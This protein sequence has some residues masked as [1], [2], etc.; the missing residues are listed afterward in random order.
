[1][2]ESLTK[3]SNRATIVEFYNKGFKTGTLWR[4]CRTIELFT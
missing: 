3:D 1:M 4:K 2:V